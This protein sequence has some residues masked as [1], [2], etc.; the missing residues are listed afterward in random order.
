MILFQTEEQSVLSP[1]Y[2]FNYTV[3]YVSD[4][5]LYYVNSLHFTLTG[6]QITAKQLRKTSSA[7]LSLHYYYYFKRMSVFKSFQATL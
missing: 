1:I 5:Y 2:H 4:N 3:K 6:I 7:C